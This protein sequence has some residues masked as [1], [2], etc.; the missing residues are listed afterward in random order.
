MT[1]QEILAQLARLGTEQYKATLMRHG[2]VEPTYGVKIED[3]KKFQ[4]KIKKD[5]RLSLELFDSGVSDAM[6]LAGLIADETQMTEADL[7][8]WA[9]RARWCMIS[10]YTVPWVAAESRCGFELAKQWIGSKEEHIA[11]CGWATLSGLCSVRAD[12]D[13]PIAPLDKLL[14]RVAKMIHRAPNRV[15]YVMNGFVIA[16]GSYVVPLHDRALEIAR[17][18]GKVEVD[19]GDTA[20]KVPSAA[21]YIA[22]VVQAGRLGKKRKATRC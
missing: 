7:Q 5:Y 12:T 9:E 6:Y 18:I 15:R 14:G 20:C 3:L 11:A 13:L 19:M 1:A 22:K 8:S 2:A 10:E 17:Q 21:D 4:K 16:A